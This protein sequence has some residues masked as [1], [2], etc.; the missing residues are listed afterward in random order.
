MSSVTYLFTKLANVGAFPASKP[1]SPSQASFFSSALPI[2]RRRLSPG[3]SATASYSSFWTALLESLPS[4]FTLQKI[5]ASLFAHISVPDSPLDISPPSRGLVKREAGLLLGIVGNLRED[6]KYILDNTSAIILSRNWTEGHTR[7]YACWVAGA[8]TCIVDVH[9]EHLVTCELHVSQLLNC[10]CRR[11]SGS[12]TGSLDVRGA[13]QAF[14]T[15]QAS[16]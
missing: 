14:L 9:G 7:V 8:A 2:I 4:P 11:V 6:R 10:S 1:T 5:L 15:S 3:G 13:H 16:L 12:D